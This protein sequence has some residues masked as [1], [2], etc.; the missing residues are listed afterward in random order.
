M[1][2]AAPHTSFTG[3]EASL[4]ADID[5]NGHAAI[6]MV[7][8]GADPSSAGWGCMDA[9]GTPVTV[10]GVKWTP[11]PAVS[12]KSYRGLVAFDDSAHSWVG[13]RTLWNE[14]AYHVSN[15]C[16]DLDSA[17][18]P[19]NVYGSIPKVERKNW[20]LPWLNNFRQNVQDQGLFNA[21]DPSVSLTVSCGAPTVLTVSVRN[22]GLAGLPSGVDVGIYKGSVSPANQIGKVTTNRSLLP[23]QTEPLTF[24]VPAATGTSADTYVA[25]VIISATN[26][27]FHECTTANNT[28]DPATAKCSQ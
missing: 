7:T 4:V 27:T 25:Q 28:S 24:T 12:N 15:I 17:C 26:P 5:G 13:T 11:N 19:P 22:V 8:N 6:L 16:D 9:S 10:N 18:V 20:S 21:P 2:F 14:H 1:R 3:T 23:G